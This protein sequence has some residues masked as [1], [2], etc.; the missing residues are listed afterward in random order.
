[1]PLSTDTAWPAH[2]LEL[3]DDRSTEL[4]PRYRYNGPYNTLL[5]YG[6]GNGDFGFPF[7]VAPS[8]PPACDIDDY[9]YML[10]FVV[11]DY[12][13][14]PVLIDGIHH[15]SSVLI[16][17]MDESWVDRADSRLKAD[18]HMRRLYDSIVEC[19]LPRLYGLS[20]LGTSLRIY[21]R[22]TSTGE[23]KPTNGPITGGLPH[24][25]L[26]GAWD[27]DILSQKGFDLMKEIVG[28]IVVPLEMERV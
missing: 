19:P 24:N 22:D 15:G 5:M 11:E 12:R 13:R 17:S 3:F 26:E 21:V 16:V 10:S 7:L 6:I 2:L 8:A 18:H 14:P 25:F 28:E 23:I 27:I 20:L 1:M 9:N 4:D